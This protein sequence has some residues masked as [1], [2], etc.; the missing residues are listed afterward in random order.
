MTELFW[1]QSAA[2]FWAAVCFFRVG[3][4]GKQIPM[5]RATWSEIGQAAVITVAVFGLLT[6]GR[7]CASMGTSSL[8][9][10]AC[11]GDASC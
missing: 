2:L 8:D 6:E 10:P 9:P 11:V 4:Q 1:W 3:A 7:G 5:T